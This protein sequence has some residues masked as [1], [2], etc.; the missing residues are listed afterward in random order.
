MQKAVP[1]GEGAMA[2]LLGLEVE[3]AQAVAA[4]SAK[5]PDGKTEVCQVAND[6]GGGQVVIS[7]AKAA[8]DRSLDI[9]KTKGAKRAIPLPVSAPFH[10]ALMKPAADVMAEALGETTMV[11]PRVPLVANVTASAVSDPLTI[12][13]LLVQQV[14]AMVRW[15]ES[16]LYMKEQGVTTLVE[17]GAGKVLTGLAKRIHPDLTGVSLQTPADIETFAK[18][19]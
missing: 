5:T 3:A 18:T 14:T 10:C 6:N 7:G 8:I 13:D 15:R 2:A 9:A 17:L 11:P 1:V 4:E 16:C 12:R 19:L